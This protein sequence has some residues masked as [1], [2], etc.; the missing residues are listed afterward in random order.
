MDVLLQYPGSNQALGDILKGLLRIED[1]KSCTFRAAVAFVK[2]SGIRHIRTELIQFVSNG[3]KAKIVVG[4]D[5]HGSSMEGLADLLETMG[6]EGELFVNHDELS[7]VTFHP[8]IFMLQKHETATLIVGSGN[9]T[10]GGLYSNDEG[11]SVTE[12]HMRREEDSHVVHRVI[13]AIDAWTDES[14]GVVRRIDHKVLEELVTGGYVA[15]ES[16][17]RSELGNDSGAK[18]SDQRGEGFFGLAAGRRRP[19]RLRTP[20]P[21]RP[22]RR[23]EGTA[24]PPIADG[25][26]MTLMQT[27][28]GV[29]QKTPGASRRS[30]E[31]FIPLSARDANPD[32]WG[33]PKSFEED[34]TNPGK[35]D[36]K[37]VEMNIIGHT[38]L[39]NMMTWPAKHDFRLRSEELRS[40]GEVGDILRIEKAISPAPFDFV[41]MVIPQGSQDFEEY[42]ALCNKK[43]PN[44]ARVW[45]YYRV[46]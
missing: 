29:G 35:M 22:E 3:G 39:V 8:K 17:T 19:A 40:A 1:A 34:P 33:W 2:R 6:T 11:V 23:R 41:V 25:F 44:S 24:G 20:L 5:H 30:P 43:T 31:V 38:A 14:K 36:R 9:L 27:D 4:I 7:H 16:R 46:E 37:G 28:A 21:A 12:L 32:F 26:V 15:K 18:R 45:G 13:N 10:E 42:L